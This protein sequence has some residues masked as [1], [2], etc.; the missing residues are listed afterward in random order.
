MASKVKRLQPVQQADPAQQAEREPQELH[1]ARQAINRM[2]K[3]I[4]EH[5]VNLDIGLMNTTAQ[6]NAACQM[7]VAAGVCTPEQ[8]D[9]LILA[10]VRSQMA[11]ILQAVEQAKL[12]AQKQAQGLQVVERPKLVIAKH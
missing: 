3:A 10:Q 8:M 12:A 6:A 11:Q 9:A 1:E 7:L 2:G 4:E 5:G